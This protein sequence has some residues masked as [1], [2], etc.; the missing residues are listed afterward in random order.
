[1]AKHIRLGDLLVEGGKLTETQLMD[2]LSKQ[3]SSGRKLGEILVDDGYVTEKDI[4]E[5]IEVQLGIPFINFSEINIDNKVV[6]TVPEKLARK[7]TLVPVALEGEELTIAMADPLNIFAID[8]V[9]MTTGLK[10]QTA[11]G[12]S[13]QIMDTINKVYSIQS[14]KKTLPQANDLDISEVDS[15]P[16][17]QMVNEMIKEAVRKKASDIHIEPFEDFVRVRYRVDGVLR[18]VARHNKANHPAIITRIKIMSTLDIA[19]KRIPQDGRIELN[20]EGADIDLRVSVLPTIYG[21]KIVMR[22]LNRSS[23]LLTKQ[24]LGFNQHNLEMF[25]NIVKSSNGIILVTG[26]TGSG[27]TTTL[28]AVLRELN[29]ISK[30][31]VTIEDPI[32]YRLSGINQVQVNNKAG[33]TFARGLR[34]ILRQDPN[35][36]MIGE[37]RDQE[38]AEIAI[39]AAVTGHLVLSTIHT[40]DAPST[41]SR[42]LDMDIEPY[43]LA[44]SLVGITAQ[45]LVRRICPECKEEYFASVEEASLL[46]IS[47]GTKL[48][49]GKGCSSCSKS[50]Y[51]GRA[52]VHEILP[53]NSELRELIGQRASVSTIMEKGKELGMITLQEN[54]KDLVLNGVST[55]EE[56]LRVTYSIG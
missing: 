44:S 34:S 42:L 52:G 15:S 20:I 39:R 9:K 36:V 25:E 41:I 10:I 23:F 29:T 55:V 12:R 8:D 13:D 18:E 40:N 16:I 56:W 51:K 28:Y 26:P 21:E 14:V 38:T 22:L 49:R 7:Y 46:N 35:I 2:A 54:A 31:I 4:L 17:V 11:I 24:Q 3:K 53:I 30:N 37:I 47:V 32:E 45:R 48:Y 19:E 33:M 1:M 43:L 5:T 50:G 6:K 27:K